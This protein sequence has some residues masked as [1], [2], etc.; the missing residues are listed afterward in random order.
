MRRLLALPLLTLVASA[1]AAQTPASQGALPPQTVSL[2]NLSAF[3]SPTPNWKVAGSASGERA[4]TA[5]TTE[6]GTGVLVNTP[7]S[8]AMGHLLTTWEHGDLD[9]ALDV[10]LPKGSNSGV[11]LM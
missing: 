4:G 8:G 7:A 2:A 6:T 11:Y 1:G 5:L 9:L 3:R 10:M